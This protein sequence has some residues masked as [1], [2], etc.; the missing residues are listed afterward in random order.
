MDAT[1]NRKQKTKGTTGTG[2]CREKSTLEAIKLEDYCIFPEGYGSN[3]LYHYC[4][5]LAANMIG[6]GYCEFGNNLILKVLHNN[7]NRKKARETP[8]EV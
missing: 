3:C 5:A 2:T 8:E 6:M 7:R 1:E 4:G